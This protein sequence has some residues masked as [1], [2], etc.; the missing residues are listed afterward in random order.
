MHTLKE[1]RLA[2][3]ESD[4]WSADAIICTLDMEEKFGRKSSVDR[5]E[6]LRLCSVTICQD[7]LIR[8]VC[9]VWHAHHF[10]SS[11]FYDHGWPSDDGCNSSRNYEI[12]HII[13]GGRCNLQDANPRSA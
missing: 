7:S 4:S 13:D 11:I 8:L 10:S 1:A 9:H 3:E 12:E 2:N 5:N 6:L